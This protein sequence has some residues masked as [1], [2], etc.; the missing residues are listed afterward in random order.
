MF[1]FCSLEGDPGL[2]YSQPRDDVCNV[3]PAHP[4]PPARHVIPAKAG[5]S[6]VSPKRKI[7]LLAFLI[8]SSI[9]QADYQTGLD[10]YN[11]NR[12]RQALSEW[13]K[14]I[15]SP[16][17]EVSPATYT[18][19]HYAIAMLYWMGQGVTKDYFE[20]S[21][22]MHKAAEL[23][24]SGA[25]SKLGFMYSQGIA[26]EHNYQQAFLW[27]SKAAQQGDIDGQYNLGV[28]YLN[29]WGTEQDKT[30]A[31][32]YLSAASAQ[33]DEH[34]EL[35]LQT[36]LP[37]NVVSGE[38]GE[39]PGSATRSPGITNNSHSR[40]NGSPPSSASP[41]TQIFPHTWIM[42]QNP[43]HYTIQVI[44]LRKQ[45]SLGNLIRDHDELAPFASY[46]LIRNSKPLYMLVQG[47]YSSVKEAQ[48][49]RDSFPATLQIPDD[50]WIRKFDKVQ[51]M[52]RTEVNSHPVMD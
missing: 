22:W 20:A 36:L 10:A 8:L 45:S 43:N 31:A 34:A 49:A 40:E 5:I 41:G 19:T 27:F 3:I 4:V 35:L 12:F 37:G 23:G 14:V 50:V 9:S 39:I 47:N 38:M 46:T 21:N 33:G 1:E 48:L 24:H 15:S 32:Q 17:G 2:C 42:A 6:P 25:Q 16:P 18:E 13:Q 29:G 28:F 44:G 11:A 51:D 30:M 26:V 52:I 7:L